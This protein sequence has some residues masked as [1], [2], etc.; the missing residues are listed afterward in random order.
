MDEVVN[1]MTIYTAVLMSTTS[2]ISIQHKQPGVV[3][4]EIFFL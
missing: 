1:I 4:Q 3:K 2:T